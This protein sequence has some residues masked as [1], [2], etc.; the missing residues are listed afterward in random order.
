MKWMDIAWAEQGQKEISGTAGDN[1]RILDYFKSLAIHDHQLIGPGVSQRAAVNMGGPLNPSLIVV[2]DTAGRLD[3]GSSVSWF[4]SPEC[5]TSAHIV[6]ERDGSVVQM[7]PL[8]RKAFHAGESVWNG[9]RYCNG[10]SVGIEIVSPGLLDRDGG[11]WFG[12]AVPAGTPLDYRH[13]PEHGAGWW[14]PYTDAQIAAVKDVCRAIVTAYPSCQEIATHWQI[15][16]GRKIDTGPLFP[17]ADVTAY[18]LAEPPVIAAA[19]DVSALSAPIPVKHAPAQLL[20]NS[21]QLPPAVTASAERP[22]A[23]S[24]SAWVL[25]LGGVLTTCRDFVAGWAD[26]LLAALPNIATDVEAQL[27]SIK[28]VGGLLGEAGRAAFTPQTLT[29]LSLACTAYAIYRL[30]KPRGA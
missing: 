12:Q 18:A 26:T 25:A 3:K 5:K 4:T 2:H 11:A 8:N 14:L 17:L 21:E 9:Q 24:K 13:T 30:T 7:V 6:I 27:D 16:P 10:F 23:K 20:G 19:L 15:S 28:A 29:Y 1:P 22:L